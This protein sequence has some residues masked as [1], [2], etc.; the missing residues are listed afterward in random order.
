MW[1]NPRKGSE[2]FLLK[3]KQLRVYKVGVTTVRVL[4][5]VMVARRAAGRYVVTSGQFTDDAKEIDSGRNIELL[6]GKASMS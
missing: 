6:E 1:R 3:C 4:Y 2:I 5:G